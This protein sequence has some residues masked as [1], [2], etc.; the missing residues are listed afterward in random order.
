MALSSTGITTSLVGNAIGSSSRNVGALCSSSLINEWSKWKPISSNVG[1]MTL[2]ELKNRNY[3]ISILSANTPDSLV[4]QIKNNSNLGY[5]YN[6]PIGGANSPYRLGDFRNYDHSAAMP[7]GASYKNGDSV[8]VGGVTSSNHASYEK[9]LM[10]IENMDG[11]DSATYL[12]KDNLYTVYDNS[13]NKI[14]LKRGALVTDG[15]NTVWYSD[16]LYWW[17]T[18][19]QKFKGKTVTVYEFY[20]NATNTPT[21]AY[22]AN[23]ND[24]FLALPEPVYTIQVKNDVPAG[25]KIVN[26]I[27]TAKFTNST[28]QYVSYE[29]KFSAVGATYRGGTITNVRAVLSKDRNGV[30]VIASTF[31][32]NSLYIAD[33]TTSQTFTGQLYNRGGSMMAYLLIYYNNSIQYTTGILAEMPDI[34]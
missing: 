10:G 25:S 14:G 7:V 20:T 18:Q 22:V 15:T 33:E 23:A 31:L 6:K 3:G 9:V 21:N 34:Q 2:A 16:K 19:M 13:G 8:N 32:S 4:T 26:T 1:T 17:T 27:C 29:I 28:N 24:R 30:N 12:S 11:G 5:K